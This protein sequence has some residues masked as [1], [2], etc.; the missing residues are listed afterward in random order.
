ME[1]FLPPKRRRGRQH[2]SDDFRLLNRFK[3]NERRHLP[4]PAFRPRVDVPTTTRL[5]NRLSHLGHPN[6]HGTTGHPYVRISMLP[7]DHTHLYPETS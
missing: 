7:P 6:Q 2:V 5:S 1:D 4:H 3:V